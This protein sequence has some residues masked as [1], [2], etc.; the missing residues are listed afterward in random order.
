M[1]KYRRVIFKY[2]WQKLLNEFRMLEQ[3]HGLWSET[4]KQQRWPDSLLMLGCDRSQPLRIGKAANPAEKQ[5][6]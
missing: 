6:A 2:K 5:H 3:P 1:K 4:K